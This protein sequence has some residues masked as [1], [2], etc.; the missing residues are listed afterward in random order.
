[1]TLPAGITRACLATRP[2][3]FRKGHAGLALI[4]QSVMGHDPCSGALFLFRSKRGDGVRRPAWDQTGLVPVR[5]KPEGGAFHWP[6][7]S[8]GVLRLSPAQ[9]SALLEGLDWVSGP[10]RAAAASAAGGM[11]AA[12]WL[13]RSFLQA[14]QGVAGCSRA[15]A[16]SRISAARAADLE[17]RLAA[18]E[19][20]RTAAE[21]ARIDAEARLAEVEEA[22][23]RLERLLAQ[24]RRAT[25]GAT[26]EKRDPGQHDLPFEDVEAAAG[27][28]AAASEAAA[29]AAGARKKTP[30]AP[31]PHKG[32]LPPHLPRIE[33]VIEPDS[34][35]CPCGCGAMQKVGESR[36][37][38]L[39][40]IPAQ[41]RVLVTVRPKHVRRPCN[42]ARHAQTPAPE[43]LAP[44]GL[45]TEA[46]VAHGMVAKFADYLPFL[47]PVRDLAPRGDRPR[48]QH[49]GGMVG[50]GCA[51][52]GPRD[53]R[54]DGRAAPQRPAPDGRDCTG[55]RFRDTISGWSLSAFR[56]FPCE[57][58]S[59]SGSKTEAILS[60]R[61]LTDA[62]W[63]RIEGHLPGR[64][65]APGRS[66]G[67][68][69]PFAGAVA[70]LARTAAP[71]RDLPPEFGKWTG[72]HARFRRWAMA[73]VWERLFNELSADPDFE[74]VLIDST[75]CK[76]HADATGGRGGLGLR[77]SGGR[78]AA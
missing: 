64:E 52:A 68:D 20:A 37:E 33:Q 71:R 61:T 67:D 1:M 39:D 2:V 76:A 18:S 74:H 75:T 23:A 7:P 10:G 59:E 21:T 8:G 57:V 77:G 55:P 24:M 72:A 40:V 5:K 73:G 54:D 69:R 62:Q 50:A 48:P 14:W 32:R 70:W 51:A 65:G 12:G 22:R 4:V 29:K 66:G 31:Q 26:S 3:D 60:R 43:R 17:R 15:M 38:R 45:P 46:L 44:R 30:R 28:L 49:A 58:S 13:G 25:F 19:A 11:A 6:K 56:G 42:G 63:S 16:S 36:V 47:P 53:R 9:F 34:I 78:A 41:F 27:M 35:L